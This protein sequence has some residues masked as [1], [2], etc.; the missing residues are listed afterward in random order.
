MW[1]QLLF[2][3][4]PE[5]DPVP[6]DTEILVLP[7]DTADS[8]VTVDTDDDTG[9]AAHSS[10]TGSVLNFEPAVLHETVPVI[11]ADPGA[12]DI[13]WFDRRFFDVGTVAEPDL[14]GGGLAVLDAD[15]DGALDLFLAGQRPSLWKQGPDQFEEVPEA[16]AGVELSA[17]VAATAVD[18]DDDGDPDLIVTQWEAPAVLL[19]NTGGAFSDVST[20][21]GLPSLPHHSSG[22][23][24]ADYDGDGL[25]D[26][27]VAGYGA[28]PADEFDPTTYTPDPSRLFRQLPVG[29]FENKSDLLAESV[30]Q[31]YVFQHGWI[32]VNGDAWPE[33]FTIV[34]YATVWPSSLLRNDRGTLVAATMTG[35]DRPYSGM[36]LGFGDLNDDGAPDLL[37]TSLFTISLM[38]TVANAGSDVGFVWVEAAV[39]NTLF[40]ADDQDFGWGAELADL[41]NDGDLD[42]VAGFGAWP[43]FADVSDPV[44]HD[45]LWERNSG[46]HYVAKGRA[47]GFDDPGATRGL[48]AV[49]V[50]GN[51]WLDLVRG[52]LDGPFTLDLA[53]CGSA[54]WLAVSLTQLP[55]NVDAVGA[56]VRVEAGGK[57]YTRW[58]DAGSRSLYV[59][60]P[61]EALV[62]LAENEVVDLIH[63]DWPDGTASEVVGPVSVR[64]RVDLQRLS[65]PGPRL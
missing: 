40:V 26:V 1:T 6:P 61:P 37:Q 22:A 17:A 28:H 36:S 33:L 60:G 8:P 10:D 50:D 18:I 7:T 64:Q 13:A 14:V 41:D 31:A 46:G 38:T 27:I 30:Q 45:E 42:A 59:G 58:I 47:H 48:L 39:P 20:E 2:G 62:G 49:D 9:S 53:R 43:R 16:L 34:D 11:C 55:P 63:V 4:R 3:C 35:I 56:R 65:A 5:P 29:G 23:A 25:L 44:E 54:A 12:R 51:G 52:E 15:G 19:L 57:T 32:D 21:W 24:V